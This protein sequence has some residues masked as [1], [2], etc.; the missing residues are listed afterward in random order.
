MI[1]IRTTIDL[2]KVEV[3]RLKL[4]GYDIEYIETRH[5][6]TGEEST[7]VWTRPSQ[8]GDIAESEIP[9]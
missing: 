6:D 8:L 3:H 5:L 9:F 2:R 1:T 4:R 7:I